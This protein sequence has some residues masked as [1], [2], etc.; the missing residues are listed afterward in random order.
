[1]N[2]KKILIVDDDYDVLEACQLALVDDGHDAIRASS[3]SEAIEKYFVF[4]PDIVFMD[5]RMPGMDGY[6]AFLS[7]RKRDGDARIV[8]T[9]SYALDDKKYKN[10]KSKSL[11]GMINKPIEWEDMEQMIKRYAK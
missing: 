2:S 9:S 3:G 5:V 10:A 8:L 1:M 6:E 4:R 11:A 7:I